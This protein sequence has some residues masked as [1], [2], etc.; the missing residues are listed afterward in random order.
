M[1]FCHYI[2]GSRALRPPLTP[3]SFHPYPPHTTERALWIHEPT[4]RPAQGTPQSL[5]DQPQHHQQQHPFTMSTAPGEPR[6]ADHF[7]RRPK[8]CASQAGKFFACFSSKGE[9]PE[10]GVRTYV[11]GWPEVEWKGAG[12]AWGSMAS[13]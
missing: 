3:P 10:G 5:T 9:Q 11:V 6:V 7:P 13:D 1:A 2:A 4:D 12:W 8:Q